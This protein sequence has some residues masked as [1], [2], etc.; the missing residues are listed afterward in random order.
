MIQKYW[1][2]CTS[3]IA[4][5]TASFQIVYPKRQPRRNAYAVKPT[6]GIN[7]VYRMGLTPKPRYLYI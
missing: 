1:M 4:I 5:Y 7:G 2:A 3:I 6:L